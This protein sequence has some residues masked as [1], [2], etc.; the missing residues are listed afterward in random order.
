MDEASRSNTRFLDRPL[1]TTS[2]ILM[3][4]AA[5]LVAGAILAPLW[6][7]RLEAPMYEDPLLMDI[8]AHK[9]ESGNDGQD[10]KEINTLNKYVGMRTIQEADFTEM[11]W[12]PFVLGGFALLAL[13]A[14]FFGRIRNAV[15]VGVLFAYFGAFSLYRFYYQMYVYAQNLDPTA[16]MNMEPFMPAVIGSNTVANFT[17]WSYPNWGS[18]LLAGFIMLVVA[19]IWRSRNESHNAS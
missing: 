7:I 17:Q 9:L 5:L 2:R 3:G 13:R 15:D 14:M 18:A 6:Q 12:M 4:L 8:Y 10:L 1:N 11:D 16:P 19:A